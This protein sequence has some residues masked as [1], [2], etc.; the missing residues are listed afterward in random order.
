[1]A[2]KEEID[3]TFKEDCTNTMRQSLSTIRNKQ[4]KYENVL[5]LN[6]FGFKPIFKRQKKKQ[7]ERKNVIR[8]SSETR[9]RVFNLSQRLGTVTET[10][11]HVSKLATHLH[12][13]HCD[14]H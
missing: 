4:A 3:A 6:Y 8:L 10:Q 7:K 13:V 12:F 1:M 14:A 2:L 11:R 5:R 9:S